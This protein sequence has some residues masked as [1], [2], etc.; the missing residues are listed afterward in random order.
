MLLMMDVCTQNVSSLEYMNKITLL[1]QVGISHYFMMKMH[2]QTTLNY[3]QCLIITH[4]VSRMP[5]IW[6]FPELTLKC[7]KL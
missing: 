6:L 2:G 7:G 1:H 3:K 5:K 4:Q